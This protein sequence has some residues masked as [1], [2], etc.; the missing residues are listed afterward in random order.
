MCVCIYIASGN[1]L[2]LVVLHAELTM[3]WVGFICCCFG[4]VGSL[5]CLFVFCSLN[6][7]VH[8]IFSGMFV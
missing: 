8:D 1:I 7:F 3:L 4:V 2:E 6:V 5:F